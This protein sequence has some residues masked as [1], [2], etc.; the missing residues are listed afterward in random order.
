MGENG[1][2]YEEHIPR[3]GAPIENARNLDPSKDL[4]GADIPGDPISSA[5]LPGRNPALKR[6]LIVIV[7]SNMFEA[8]EQSLI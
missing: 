5:V 3:F 4:K 7:P 8:A 1:L 2:G 6:G